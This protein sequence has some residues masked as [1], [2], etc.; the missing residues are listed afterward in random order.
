MAPDMDET[1]E[2]AASTSRKPPTLNHL[3]ADLATP[4]LEIP[5]C[6]ENSGGRLSVLSTT[7]SS[8]YHPSPS[9]SCSG[10]SFHNEEDHT[11][12]L[13][14]LTPSSTLQWE[15]ESLPMP[16]PAWLERSSVATNPLFQPDQSA[17]SL[18]EGTKALP[19]KALSRTSR[20]PAPPAASHQQAA[21]MKARPGSRIP[22]MRPSSLPRVPMLN[23]AP[24]LQHPEANQGRA[25][26]Y[27]VAEAGKKTP[28]A[29]I[30]ACY[31]YPR[32]DGDQERKTLALI[33]KL[34]VLSRNRLTRKQALH[35]HDSMVGAQQK[36]E[37]IAFRGHR[38]LGDVAGHWRE[39]L[40]DSARREE[41]LR[42]RLAVAKAVC[43]Q[44]QQQLD[45]LSM[46][47]QGLKG[48][49]TPA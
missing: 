41:E 35:L 34:P 36:Y 37:A 46:L 10:W 17:I 3:F 33:K 42:E 19:I 40:S 23:L 45:S 2:P 44:Q 7:S 48:L 11:L 4:K 30:D 39:R 28:V 21:I 18:E 9:R 43:G 27:K 26:A 16:L 15:E 8:H 13:T 24:L 47:I 25:P 1:Q 38:I 14:L 5:A 29:P 20:I 6:D 22:A 49:I 32:V 31:M 12:E